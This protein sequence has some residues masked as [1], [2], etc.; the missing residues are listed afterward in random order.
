MPPFLQRVF[1]AMPFQRVVAK[2]TPVPLSPPSRAIPP[3]VRRTMP[4]PSGDKG[5]AKT[6]AEMR[7]L[8]RDGSK[9]PKVREL[10][11]S[12]AMHHPDDRGKISSI[13]SFVQSKMRYVRDPLHQ[14]MLGGTDYH[15]DTMGSE[16]AMRGDCDDHTIMLG[17]MLE[18]VGYPT[19][20]TT[21]RVKPGGTSYDHVYLEAFDRRGWI[22]LDAANKKKPAGEAPP[23]R[24]IRRW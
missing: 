12:I 3:P 15:I 11:A 24:R 16:G 5:T 20:I 22:P 7:R 23:A 14:E 4:I 19:R 8:I 21:V 17:A 1:T 13:F 2:P 9:Q 18:S 6:V 10:A